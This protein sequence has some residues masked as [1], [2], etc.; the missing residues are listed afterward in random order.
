LTVCNRDGLVRQCPVQWRS[1]PKNLG[2]AKMFDFRR[3]TLFCL[4]KRYQSTKWL[5]F[6]KICWGH[7]PS[8]SSGYAYDPVGRS[9]WVKN[10]AG[11]T[12][13]KMSYFTFKR[14]TVNLF[15]VIVHKIL[16]MGREQN[17]MDMKLRLRVVVL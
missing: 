15:A 9:G 12:D 3:M 4:E 16:D 5:Y 2:G 7:G 13:W 1:Q 6:L 11:I 8:A 17:E 10:V 14:S